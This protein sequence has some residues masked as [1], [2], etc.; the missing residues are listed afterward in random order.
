MILKLLEFKESVKKLYGRFGVYI[1]MVLKFLAAFIVFSIIN[2]EMGY[3]AT[4]KNPV[5]VIGLS[6]I[7]ALTPDAIF[8]I[9]AMALTVFHAYSISPILAFVII[10][11]YLIIYF[12]YARYVPGQVYVI[13]ALPVMYVLG[14]PYAVP[15]VCGIFMGPVSIISN[16]MGIFVY[17]MLEEVVNTLGVSAG[18]SVSNTVNFFNVI[19]DDLRSNMYMFASMAVFAS[20]VLVTYIIRRQKIKYAASIAILIG[21]L[22]NVVAFLVIS[23]FMDGADTRAAILTGSALSIAIAYVASF[24][25]MSLDYSGT[26]HIQFEDDEYYYYVKAVPKLSVSAPDKQVKTIHAQSPG[27]NTANISEIF[28]VDNNLSNKD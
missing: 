22:I 2:N 11:V 23:A 1:R 6:I 3:N 12:M 19:I 28:E 17:F 13:I 9:L 4:L 10:V 7:S 21:S 18:N 26:K 27:T 24:F 20:V 15:L 5:I 16:A 8:I 25:R 14:I